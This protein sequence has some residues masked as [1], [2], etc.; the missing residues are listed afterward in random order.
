M[1]KLFAG[2]AK[3]DITPKIGHNLSGWHLRREA[4]SCATPLLARA[5]VLDNEDLRIVII[6]CDLL[7]VQEP[8]SGLIRTNPIRDKPYPIFQAL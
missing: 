7:A 6:T 8:L 1:Y 2:T 5:L 3:I 4:K